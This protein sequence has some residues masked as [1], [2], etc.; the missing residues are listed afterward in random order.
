MFLSLGTLKPKRV[1]RNVMESGSTE[2]ERKVLIFLI[3]LQGKINISIRRESVTKLM[4]LSLG[5]LKPKCVARNVMESGSTER[6]R[7]VLIFLIDL[8]GKINISIRRESVTKLMFLSLGTL[9][10]KCVARNVMESG[11]TGR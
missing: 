8:Q 11:S 2:R 5:T 4:F 3:D 1:A 6:E 9:K 10:P 7:K